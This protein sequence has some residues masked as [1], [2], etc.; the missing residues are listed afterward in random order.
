[1]GVLL[2]FDFG[3]RRIGIATGQGLTDTASPLMAIKARDG[4]PDWDALERLIT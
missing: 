1:M 3:L 2:G 4:I